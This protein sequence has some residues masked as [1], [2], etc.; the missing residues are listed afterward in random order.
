MV[1]HSA[2]TRAEAGEGRDDGAN[3]GKE[4]GEDDAGDPE[5]GVLALDDGDTC[6]CHQPPAEACVHER[7]A[8]AEGGEVDGGRPSTIGGPGGQEHAQRTG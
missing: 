5:A 1:S 3:A 7:P 6:G 4:P 8:V 2:P